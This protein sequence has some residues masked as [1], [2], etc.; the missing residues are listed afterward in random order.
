MYLSV[1][2]TIF[3]TNPLSYQPYLKYVRKAIIIIIIHIRHI[4]PYPK[5]EFRYTYG[6]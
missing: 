4:T 5:I 6:R 3:G 2:E 1:D